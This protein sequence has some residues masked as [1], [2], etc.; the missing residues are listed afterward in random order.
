[1]ASPPAKRAR[2][3]RS[4]DLAI[5]YTRFSQNYGAELAL[6]E[7]QDLRRNQRLAVAFAGRH[8]HLADDL[9]DWIGQHIDRLYAHLVECLQ[10]WATVDDMNIRE[11]CKYIAQL[12][13]AQQCALVRMQ[14]FQSAYL[15]E[16][17]TDYGT[18]LPRLTVNQSC[19]AGGPR[20][21]QN[22]TRNWTESTGIMNVIDDTL[23]HPW[24]CVECAC[25]KEQEDERALQDLREELD[26]I[27][28]PY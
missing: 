7:E 25:D 9:I 26:R 4:G 6:F 24:L 2:T 1:M 8:H 19:W 17:W 18:I 3:T 28:Y 27:G 5:W 12:T 10:L 20:Q 13:A 15:S 22:C 21:C 16:T 23:D 14:V 11:K